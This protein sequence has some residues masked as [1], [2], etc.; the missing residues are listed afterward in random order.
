MSSDALAALNDVEQACVEQ[1]LETLAANLGSNLH[2]VWLFGSV[3]RQ[4]LW[5]AW[6]PMRSDV[7]LLVLTHTSVPPEQ[8]QR[9]VDATYPLYLASGRQISPQFW[10]RQRFEA[11]EEGRAAEFVAQVLQDGKVL[12]HD[13]P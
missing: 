11:P 3:A 12:R 6:M 13:G 2:A 4:D 1:Y 5:P 8:A 7:D 10:T 9:L